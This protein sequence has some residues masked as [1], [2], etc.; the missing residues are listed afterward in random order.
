[1]LDSLFAFAIFIADF[2]ATLP[3]MPPR[4]RFAAIFAADYAFAIVFFEA[5][6]SFRH[7]G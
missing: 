7:Y 4:R 6:A 1:L 3:L 5:E 2:A